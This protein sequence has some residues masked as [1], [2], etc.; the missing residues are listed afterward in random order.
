MDAGSESVGELLLS[1][2]DE[3]SKGCNC[4]FRSIAITHS[5]GRRSLILGQGDQVFR[6][7]RLPIRRLREILRQKHECGLSHRAIASAKLSKW[8][9]VVEQAT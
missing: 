4:L 6:A 9:Q 1:Q 2:S 7:L 5:G 3:A 8:L